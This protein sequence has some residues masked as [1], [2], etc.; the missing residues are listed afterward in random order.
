MSNPTDRA[1]ITS[2]AAA[3]FAGEAVEGVPGEGVLDLLV[4]AM[5]DE[6]PL[7][8]LQDAEANIVAVDGEDDVRVA[9]LAL[10]DA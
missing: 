5:P 3:V 9:E 8:D 6:R 10:R 4:G 7:A 1:E 2:E